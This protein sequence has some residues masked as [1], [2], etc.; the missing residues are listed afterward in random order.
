MSHK[1]N[2]ATTPGQ[3]EKMFFNYLFKKAVWPREEEKE[4][5]PRELKIM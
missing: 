5:P 1:G 3:K 4:D 2:I